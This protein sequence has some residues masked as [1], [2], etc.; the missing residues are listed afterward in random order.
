MSGAPLNQFFH[1]QVFTKSIP[2]LVLAGIGYLV[3][4]LAINVVMRVYLLRDLW[5]RVLASTMVQGIEATANVSAKGELAN[6]LGEGFAD[7][8]DVAGF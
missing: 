5:V 7:G 4:A 2:L 3:F 1:P 6:A 8:L